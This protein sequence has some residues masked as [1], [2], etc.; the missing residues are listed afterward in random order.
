MTTD[1]R[2]DRMER[3]LTTLKR[4]NRCLLAV[5]ACMVGAIV[6]F[7]ALSK[8]VP[9]AHAQGMGTVAREIRAN[10]FVVVD[11]GNHPVAALEHV[12]GTTRLAFY[13]VGG[14]VR[15][16]LVESTTG[17]QLALFGEN[18]KERVRLEIGGFHFYDENGTDRVYLTQ[19]Q[20]ASG[21]AQCD[22]KG[23]SRVGLAVLPEGS[24]LTLIDANGRTR[25]E[26]NCLAKATGLKVRSAKGNVL[27]AAP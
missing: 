9:V 6:L 24:L 14:M 12:S 10:R 1:E 18:D 3:E 20:V 11:S 16:Q 15:A 2:L 7:G 5:A 21:F 17:P 22:E 19:N 27:W 23:T 4:R 8:I 13:G 26:M 25:L